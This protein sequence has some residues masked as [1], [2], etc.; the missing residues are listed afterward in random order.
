MERVRFPPVA[1]KLDAPVPSIEIVV[2]SIAR[3]GIW[4]KQNFP[5]LINPIIGNTFRKQLTKRTSKK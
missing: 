2:P 3:A 5:F 1:V 4:A